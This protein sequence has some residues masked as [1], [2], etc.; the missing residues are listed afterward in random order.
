MGI[1]G[2][3]DWVCPKCKS[4]NYEID[5]GIVGNIGKTKDKYNYF[6]EINCINCGEVTIFASKIKQKNLRYSNLFLKLL[7]LIQRK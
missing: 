6:I 3:E 1:K 4:Q 5:W 2:L 7:G